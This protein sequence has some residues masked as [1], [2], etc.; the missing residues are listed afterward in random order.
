MGKS[1]AFPDV[2]LCP[3]TP[4]TGPVPV[5]LPNTV[6]ATDLTAGAITVLIEGNQAG[7]VQSFFMKST[8]NEVARPTGGG[9][10]TMAVQGSAH[11]GSFS[12][13]VFFENQPAVRHMDILTHNHLVQPGNTPPA[14]WLSAMAPPPA[15]PRS[16]VEEF[17]GKDWI[18]IKYVN[19]LGD[20]IASA[21]YEVDPPGRTAKGN[22]L[23]GGL[24]LF[25]GIDP[26]QCKAQLFPD[27]LETK[28]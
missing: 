18:R 6:V 7:H 1:I 10:M 19:E 14:P 17:K 8:G 23:S 2:C 5:P 22:L 13:N 12:M 16:L 9:V 26:G 25:L 11:W 20:A 21:P 3:P 4:P 28:K 27:G 15:A 24:L